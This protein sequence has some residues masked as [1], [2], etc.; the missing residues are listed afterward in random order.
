M[1]RLEL[2]LLKN[3]SLALELAT[4]AVELLSFLKEYLVD[5]MAVVLGWIS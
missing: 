5:S 1:T 3:L 4:N 2:I